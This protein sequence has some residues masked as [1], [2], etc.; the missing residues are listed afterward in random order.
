MISA[1]YEQRDNAVWIIVSGHVDRSQAERFY[2]ELPALVAQ[3]G[4]GFTVVTDL[5]SLEVMDLDVAP[6]IRRGM[7]FFNQHGVAQV[8]RVIPDPAKDIG[9]NIMSMFHYSDDVA[10]LTF[11]SRDEAAAH[12]EKR[13][14]NIR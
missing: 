12:F 11:P 14:Y 6:M 7:E 1:R 3:C 5:S 4:K 8:F 13:A 10:T 9:F 2:E